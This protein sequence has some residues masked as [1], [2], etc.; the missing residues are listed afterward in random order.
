MTRWPASVRGWWE[1]L[2]AAEDSYPEFRCKGSVWR[3]IGASIPD[4]ES[5]A[6]E[7]PPSVASIV[8]DP[9]PPSVWVP[10]VRV[11]L[12]LSIASERFFDGQQ[13]WSDH[14]YRANR[15][16]L[17][18]RMYRSLLKLLSP[19]RVATGAGLVWGALHRGSKVSVQKLEAAKYEFTLRY[20]ENGFGPEFIAS[21]HETLRASLEAAG[22]HNVRVVGEQIDSSTLQWRAAWDG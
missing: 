4:V 1:S 14:V 16:L 3:L 9:P 18:G 20:P 19:A 8:T 11:D 10:M 15:A 17:E 6:P 21:S 5:I 12:A 22:A 7:L 2:P 13:A